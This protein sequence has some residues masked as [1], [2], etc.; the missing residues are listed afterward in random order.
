MDKWLNHPTAMKIIS[1]ALG[2]ILWAVVHFD[3]SQPSTTVPSS[4]YE[5]KTVNSV[6]IQVTGLNSQNYVLQSM[7]ADSVKLYVRGS[8]TDLL[9]A[10]SD[11]YQVSIDLST[12]TE[13]Q[14]TLRLQTDLPRGV[15]LVS[16]TPSTVT[17]ALEELQTKEFE[18]EIATKGTPAKGYKAGIPVLSPTNRVHVTLP[19]SGLAKVQKVGGTVSVEGESKTIKNK[20]VKLAAYDSE[21]NV[22]E[23]A[24]LDPAVLEVEV[25]ITN[26]YKSVPLQFKLIGQLPSGLSIAS[27]KPETEQVTIYGPQDVLDGIEFVEADVSLSELTK[28]GKV[29]VPLKGVTGIT[30]FSPAEVNVNV[31]IVLSQIRSL[32]GLPVTIEGVGDGLAAKIVEP[33]TEVVDITVRG[34]PAILDKLQPGD[35]DVVADLSGR[36]L[37]SY[38]VPLVVNSPRFVD[39]AGGNLTITVEITQDGA[40]TPAEETTATEGTDAGS[41]SGGT[42]GAGA[43]ASGSGGG[44]GS[45][46]TGSG[47]TAGGTSGGSGSSGSSAGSGNGSGSGTAGGSG[48]ASG[49]GSASSGTASGA[50]EGSSD[51]TTTN[52]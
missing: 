30:E 3:D 4:S 9:R 45:G 36:G 5:Y 8:K 13:G 16:I 28:S 26:P 11:D 39:Q 21:G 49:E 34:A 35:V 37:G 51:T 50:G 20:S 22:I 25:P 10:N 1:L 29:A 24:V 31:E 33:A 52:P 27:F 6:K 2:I 40:E 19:S 44:T 46:T 18:V 14:H 12:V 17:V 23:G 38:T 7:D 15:E 48:N 42:A 43:G 41:S 47:G 32:Q